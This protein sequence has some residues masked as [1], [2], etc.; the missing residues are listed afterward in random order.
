MARDEQ[1]INDLI[2]ERNRLEAEYGELLEKNEGR[3]KAAVKNR[4]DRLALDK[5]ITTEQ[6]KQSEIEEKRAQTGK[7]IEKTLAGA[8]K[9]QRQI[10]VT[11]KD[12][13]GLS[14]K[15]NQA[16]QKQLEI[17]K[18]NVI[19]G[20]INL[21]LASKLNDIGEDLIA[22]NYDLEGIQASQRDLKQELAD[23]G[24]DATEE[25]I[26]AIKG[27][28][29]VLAL[30]S[31][32]LK[33]EGLRN[34]A[35]KEADKVTGGMASKITGMVGHV[36]KVGVGFAAAGLAVGLIGAGI[37]LAVKA[38]RFVSGIID[39]LGANFGAVA[40][41]SAE[42]KDTMMDASVEVV[43][44]GKGTKDV[45]E[46][47]QELSQNFGLSFN[48]AAKMS[49]KILDSAVGMGLTNSEA[50]KLFGTLMVMGDL[51]AQ[52]AER[53]AEN[54]YQLA[55]QNGVAPVAVMK[56][57][58][59]SSE[60]I[61]EFGS[62]NLE[63][64]TNAA[65]QA[66]KMG[67]NLNT[68]K[69]LSDSLLDFQTSIKNEMEASVMIGRRLNLNSARK[70]MFEGKSKEALDEVIK[71]MGGIDKFEKLGILQKRSVAKLIG[72]EVNEVTKL[73]SKQDQSIKKQKTFNDIMGEEG[74]SSLTSLINKVTELGKTFL[75]EF[76]A[77]LE[78]YL[79]DFED[80]Y[81]TE[82]GMETLKGRIQD[83]GKSLVKVGE[84]IADAFSF[85]ATLATVGVGMSAGAKTG[86][87]I[88]SFFGPAGTGI[89]S[90]IGGLIGALIGYAAGPDFSGG[91]AEPTTTTNNDGSH[92]IV[93]PRGIKI[94][95]NPDDVLTGSTR[96]ND[97][98][99]GP[100]GSM[101]IGGNNRETIGLLTKI[102][103][104]NETL[105][106]EARRGPD[107]MVAGLGDL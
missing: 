45:V 91:A 17:T 63:S 42:F 37:S 103:E 78:E 12:S 99:S 85:M 2:E 96:V 79:G 72:M 84:E 23:L 106:N 36:K 76:G 50:A 69:K 54:T 14:T 95:T 88:G 4:K 46:V 11:A 75:L 8:A 59:N 55:A 28:Q 7:S 30:E 16:A 87:I 6:S 47:T 61:A 48:E 41:R 53:F 29:K 43:S 34:Q 67:L 38:V 24:A 25:E 92:T 33:I 22:Q 97:F 89:G 107:R 105:I 13:F 5:K 52:Q 3:S 1:K 83:F 100:P 70:L 10:K 68:V 60:M 58:A 73:L 65:I 40:T 82:D 56:D 74:L 18:D 81:F 102:V 66:R 20:R 27:K 57:I 104:Q 31:K 21:N 51:T 26:E 94:K 80:K 19:E 39:E 44:I 71:Q 93:T 77:P 49:D 101:P 32:R 9:K 86:G 64:L 15:V 62:D 35:L 98:I 90:L